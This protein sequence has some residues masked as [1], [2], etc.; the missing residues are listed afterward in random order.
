MKFD[1]SFWVAVATALFIAAVY[2]PAKRAINSLLHKR[3]DTVKSNLEQAR[4][5]KEEAQ[6]LLAEAEKKLSKSEHDAKTII[7]HANE[8]AEFIVSRARDKLKSD[9]EI[10]R[11]LAMQKIKSLE[12]SAVD[13]IK[14]NLSSL[15]IIAAQTILEEHVKD[16]IQDKLTDESIEKADK[17]IPLG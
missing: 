9:I 8:E 14:K 4:K 13:E 10:R 7:K 5:L 16:E 12:E 6:E 15:T 2:K 1:E 3:I 17:T 11:K